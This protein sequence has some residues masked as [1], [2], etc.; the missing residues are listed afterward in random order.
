MNKLVINKT[1]AD[2]HFPFSAFNRNS[3]RLYD[4]HSI[5]AI[6]AF[7]VSNQFYCSLNWILL[8]FMP[9]FW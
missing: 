8:A 7:I 3:K 2:N 4:T 9:A 5:T 1:S 6:L